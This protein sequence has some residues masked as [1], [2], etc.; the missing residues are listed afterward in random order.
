MK[1]IDFETHF[2]SR[3][4]FEFLQHHKA[5]PH[6]SFDQHSNSPRIWYSPNVSVKQG[7]LLVNRLLSLNEERIE[8]MDE[9]GIDV[10]ILSLSE[11][12]VE[13]FDPPIGTALAKSTNDRLAEAI[14]TYPGRFMGF[15]ALAPQDPAEAVKEL[16]RAVMELGFV[17]WLTHSNFGDTYLDHEM[18]WPILEQAEALNVP[19]YIHPSFP[20]ITQ[21]HDYGFALAGAP[22]GFQFETAMCL[23]RMILNGVFD[24]FPNL[25]IILG[26]FGE[27]LPFLMERIDFPFVRPWF[28]PQE[29]PKIQRKPSDVLR[30]NLFVTTSGRFYEPAFR[31]TVEALGTDRVLFGTDHP[32]ET[33]SDGVEFIESVTLSQEDK[34][35]IYHLNAARLG[36]SI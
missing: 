3:V 7:E 12:S 9:A 23:M 21:L 1:K 8:A 25:N 35:K 30:E 13:L 28:A 31:C 4:F 36:V 34:Q 24:R 20:A 6:Y 14:N 19:I 5:Y 29:R 11:P 16:T 15:A 32:Y 26:H 10:Q 27:A 33:M 17:G 22:F 2:F 18:Y